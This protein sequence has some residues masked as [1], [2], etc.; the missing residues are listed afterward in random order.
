MKDINFMYF[1]D[2]ATVNASAVSVMLDSNNLAAIDSTGVNEVTAWFAQDMVGDQDG[3]DD[4]VI[5]CTNGA[6]DQLDYEHRKGAINSMVKLANSRNRDGYV[7][8][9]DTLNSINP[10]S[11]DI[12]SIAVTLNS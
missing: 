5:T 12:V 8:A 11:T 6:T 2:N 7:V 3:P 10:N 4:V 9:F 1:N